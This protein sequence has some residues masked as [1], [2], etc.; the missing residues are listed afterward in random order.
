MLQRCLGLE[1]LYA[2][3]EEGGHS[4]QDAEDGENND[5]VAQLGAPD[6]GT[7]FVGPPDGHGTIDGQRRQRRRVQRV[8]GGPAADQDGA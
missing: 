8:S 4:D 6:A 7:V 2:V 3:G 1:I 5:V